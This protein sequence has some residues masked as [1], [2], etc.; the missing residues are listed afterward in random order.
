[1]KRVRCT[2]EDDS[3]VEVYCREEEE[4]EEKYLKK[5]KVKD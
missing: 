3:G 2:E 1:M 5:P 4:E